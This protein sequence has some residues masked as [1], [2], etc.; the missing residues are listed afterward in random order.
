MKP[1]PCLASEVSRARAT[2]DRLADEAAALHRSDP[3]RQAKRQ[4]L[5]E[6][7]R[8]LVRLAVEQRSAE[9]KGCL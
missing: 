1:T 9:A 6:A 4:A 3:T 8:T 5:A 2:R 7:E